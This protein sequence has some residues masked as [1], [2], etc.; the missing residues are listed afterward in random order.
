MKTLSE[1][2][3]GELVSTFP[4]LQNPA[5]NAEFV[6]FDRT[7]ADSL[8]GSSYVI[9]FVSETECLVTRRTNGKWVLP[10][11]T[12][13]PGESWID[14]AHREIME[15][16]GALLDNLHP[17]G[18]F[19]CVSEDNRP[20]LP[21]IPHP[22]HVRVVSCANARQI[23]QPSDP[24]G[25]STIVE[26]KKVEYHAVDQLFDKDAQDFAALYHLAYRFRHLDESESYI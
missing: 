9:P 18:M 2:R 21:H 8:S 3:F 20:R 10:G 24:D 17:L 15:E 13:E 25:D 6:P 22:V 12:L 16:T 19:H 14:A 5:R 26:T 1:T 23:R 7:L 4:S 11:G